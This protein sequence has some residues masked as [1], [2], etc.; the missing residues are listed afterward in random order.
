MMNRFIDSR[1]DW[2]ALLLVLVCAALIM[3]P[4]L[5]G[6]VVLIDPFHYGEFFAA[7]VSFFPGHV[8]A[9]APLTIHGALD[10]I[11]ALI[12][13][14]VW[15]AENYFLPT[16]AIY[17]L[18]DIVA[19]ALLLLNAHELIRELPRK[20]L[21]LLAFAMAAPFC[22]G[23]RDVLL[24]ASIYT[25]NLIISNRLQPSSRPLAL[26]VLGILV[27][28]G[29]VW[30]FD[31]GLACTLSLGLP[32]LVLAWRERIHCIALGAFVV[33][34]VCLDLVLTGFSITSYFEN[35][36]VLM[37]TSAQWSYGWQLDAMI[38]SGFVLAV[39]MAVV[40]LAARTLT[41]PATTV[42]ELLRA[43]AFLG[44]TVF[45]VKMAI[46]RADIGHVYVG[47]WV[48]ALWL[49]ADGRKSMTFGTLT[50]VA[51]VLLTVAALLLSYRFRSAGFF[52]IACALGVACCTALPPARLRVA[53]LI[54][55]ALMSLPA[56]Y[57]LY[58]GVK[59]LRGGEYQ[60]LN[61]VQSPPQNVQSATEGV[62]WV[63]ARLT[64]SGAT[65]VFDLSNNGV[66][67]GLTNLPSCSRFTY[68][69]YAAKKHESELIDSIS[70]AAP[71]A[72]VY[73]S[74]YWSYS[75][76]GRSMRER[77]TELDRFLT[78]HYPQ[79]ECSLGY[80]V[81]YLKTAAL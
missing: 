43:L 44:L 8:Q 77:F 71:K 67:N 42:N 72:I 56:A 28:C 38:M 32:M 65:C 3:A 80:C 48:P 73:S 63:A 41:K 61:S 19:A 68:P 59:S 34:V 12:A 55:A 75:I 53:T 46:N 54:S 23:Y 50:R 5:K 29:L 45:T 70:S 47:L 33:T 20:W 39:N 9:F 81:R 13:R 21:L 30:S 36:R 15:G 60:W 1:P 2:R 52:V 51:A 24:L 14:D 10:F 37:E 79:E 76:D 78:A 4:N 25:F 74:T 57:V 58:G 6:S 35:L 69:V 18:L 66:I 26:A 7:A 17:A 62:A 64:S 22:V 40:V 16:Y 27:G 11:P 49:L 31:R